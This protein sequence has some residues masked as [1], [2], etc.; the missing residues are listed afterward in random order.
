MQN[1]YQI[2]KELI[3]SIILGLRLLNSLIKHNL[4]RRNLWRM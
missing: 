4:R 3:I 2:K 1:I